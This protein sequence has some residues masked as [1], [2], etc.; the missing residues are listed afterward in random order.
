M[1]NFTSDNATIFTIFMFFYIT[2]ADSPPQNA[3]SIS[4]RQGSS[5]NSADEAHT[6][7]AFVSPNL[8]MLPEPVFTINNSSNQQSIGL[9]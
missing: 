1:N 4:V 7:S 5:W 8:K 9:T 3:P 6:V 2:R